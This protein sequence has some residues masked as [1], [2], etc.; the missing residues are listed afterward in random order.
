MSFIPPLHPLIPQ[1][2]LALLPIHTPPILISHLH[3]HSHSH[4]EEG[5]DRCCL[6]IQLCVMETMWTVRV[7]IMFV[8]RMVR[9]MRKKITELIR[10]YEIS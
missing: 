1:L 10:L 5:D 7:M 6:M 9:M 4:D 2:T 8:Q 3:P